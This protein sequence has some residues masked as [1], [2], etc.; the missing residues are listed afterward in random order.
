[1]RVLG[2]IRLS[3]S[4]DEST[5]VKRQRELIEQW[6]ETHG[7]T[8][9]AW[10]EDTDVSGSVS[11]FD[12]P[13]LGPFL[14]DEGKEEWDILVAWK[15]DRLARSSITLHRLFGWLMENDKQLVCIN[16]NIDLSGWAG[17]MLAGIIAGLAEGELEAITE[18]VTAG[19]KALREQGRF[20]GGIPPFGYRK[21]K[22]EGGTY[23]EFD[24]QEQKILRRMVDASLA[25]AS[26]NEIAAHLNED[27][28]KTKRGKAW[29]ATSVDIVLSSQAILGWVT[30]D[31]VP[32]LGPDGSPVTQGPPS[33]TLDEYN[34]I[35]ELKKSRSFTRTSPAENSPLRGVL[36]CWECGSTMHFRRGTSQPTG[37]AYR[38]PSCKP[39]VLV[40]AILLEE[41]VAEQFLDEL[42]QIEVL[43][44]KPAA[45]NVDGQLTEAQ[46]AYSQIASFLSTAPDEATRAALFEQLTLVGDRIK[47][48]E[49]QKNA[50]A[51][52]QWESTGQT[53]GGLWRELDTEGRRRL[54][55]SAGIRFRVQVIKRGSRWSPPILQ[56]ELVVPSDLRK[57]LRELPAA[58]R[59]DH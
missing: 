43:R 58:V 2:R 53:Y 37:A 14:T 32:V 55:L 12:A 24:E 40:N 48:L 33:I 39:T 46:G 44:K 23:L 5:S 38:C 16:D 30:H 9:V 26:M 49:A 29:T 51:G 4:R 25:G 18:R 17:R 45:D 42:D 11:P 19:Q 35:Q 10:A 3:R 50:P 20:R 54:M 31:G 6:A 13:A 1:M 22:K 21:V 59:T 52:G 56:T 57:Q 15:L 34:R 27:G 36:E 41:M 8:I 7:H 47:M 28:V